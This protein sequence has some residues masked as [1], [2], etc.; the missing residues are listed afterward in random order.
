[1]G[2]HEAPP[3]PASILVAIASYGASNRRYLEQLIETYR[4][5]S[6]QV[7]IVVLSNEPKD[8]GADVEVR[9]G[10]PSPD[11]WSLPFAHKALFA[12]RQDE[13]DYFIYSENDTL[14]TQANFDAFAEVE[15][16]LP[17]HCIAGF[18]RH[19]IG[20]DGALHYSTVHGSYHWEPATVQV[21]KGEV[22][23]NYSNEHSAA[24][25]LSRRKLKHCIASGGFLR[26]PHVGRYDMLCSAATDPY[27]GC[28]LQRLICV[29][30]IEEFSL[31]HM[32]DKYVGRIG[33]PKAEIDLQLAAIC[34]HARAGV[35]LAELLRPERRVPST[36]RYD[37]CYYSA[38]LPSAVAAM[39]ATPAR[40]LSVGCDQGQTEGNLVERGHAVDAIPLDPVI[41]ASSELRGVTTLPI[42]ADDPLGR[43]EPGAYGSVL[44][45]F[46]L[47]FVADPVAALR[48]AARV[49][50]PGG[51][52]VLSF[53]NWQSLR[54]TVHRRRERRSFPDRADAGDFARSGIHRTDPA[55]V[56]RWMQ[57]AGFRLDHITY[58][59]PSGKEW[60]SRL[61]LG[62][63][64]RWLAPTATAVSAPIGTPQG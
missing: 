38:P 8:L 46:Y 28:G 45:N 48:E 42:D 20:P 10:L 9:V 1:M 43:I 17:D 61:T 50:E 40:I 12:E 56:R 53:W 58:D 19:E 59:V 2:R 60:L 5:F 16:T 51:R 21:I 33:V 29:S 47:P 18:L 35:P 52:V 37:R 57:Q 49:I 6:Q 44:M 54:E 15:E 32:P 26:D 24:F 55:T 41:A 30:R 25:I 4:G 34:R 62:A 27:T 31:H 23:A 39:P 22:F 3:R 36:A 63:A 64:D 13:F 7:S 11:P 14:I